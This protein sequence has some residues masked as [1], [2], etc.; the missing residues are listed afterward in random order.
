MPVVRAEAFAAGVFD[1][2]GARQWIAEI[3]RRADVPQRAMQQ[4]RHVRD[5]F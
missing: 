5:E 3:G 2:R 4:S 1:L